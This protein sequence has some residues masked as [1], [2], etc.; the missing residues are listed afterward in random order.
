MIDMLKARGKTDS[1]RKW[2]N[3]FTNR[4]ILQEIKQEDLQ[5]SKIIDQKLESIFKGIKKYW[6]MHN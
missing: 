5:G 1:S 2:R 6:T 4:Y 3:F